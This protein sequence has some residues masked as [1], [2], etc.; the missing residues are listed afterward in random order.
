MVVSRDKN[1]AR[2]H[3]IETNI[4]SFERVEES[5]Y[6]GTILTNQ[7]YIQEEVKSR[8]K[9]GNACY[10]SVE[11]F[12]SYSFLLKNI[13]I[14]IYRTINFPVVLYGCKT[15]SLTLRKEP[16]LRMFENRLLRKIFGPKRDEVTGCGENYVMWSFTSYPIWFVSKIMR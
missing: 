3:R 9:S 2:N 12:V 10:H 16:R 15:W 5:K 14:K 1:A 8:L 4:C 6:L 11:N 7:N 13:K